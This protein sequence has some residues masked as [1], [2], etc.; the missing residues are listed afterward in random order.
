MVTATSSAPKTTS[1]PVIP[2]APSSSAG[3]TT[4]TP[5]SCSS[6][7]ASPTSTGSSGSGSG[8]SDYGSCSDPSITWA[9][10]LDGRKGWA[11]AANNQEDFAHGSSTTI[12]T[13]TGF[14]CN[15]LNSPCGAPQEML[16]L[17][18][19]SVQDVEQSGLTGEDKAGLWNEL[20]A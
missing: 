5:D 10:G 7:S 18:D 4:T 20:M 6:P 11:Y 8:A 14:I 13:L 16:D 12:A 15:R 17:C 2:S 3:G 9:K 1:T 19:Q